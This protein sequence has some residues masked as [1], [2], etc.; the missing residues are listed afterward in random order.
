MQTGAADIG[1]IALSLAIP[2]Q[3]SREGRYVAV[4][5]SSYPMIRQ[6]AVL[7]AKSQHKAEAA[8]F[9]EYMKQPQSIAVLAKYGFKPVAAAANTSK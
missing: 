3:M 6:A 7:V 5:P 2:P 9:L 1:L 8:R 4:A